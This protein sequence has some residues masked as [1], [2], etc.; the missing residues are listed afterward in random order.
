MNVICIPPAFCTV[1]KLWINKSIVEICSS[2]FTQEVA[3]FFDDSYRFSNFV[4]YVI[5]IIRPS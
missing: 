1:Y 4:F 2:I 3:S 5:K